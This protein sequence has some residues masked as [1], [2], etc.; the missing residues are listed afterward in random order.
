ML[1]AALIGYLD[2]GSGSMIVQ[3][4]VVALAGLAVVSKFYGRAI[5]SFLRRGRR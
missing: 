1:Q 5:L 2:T 3:L 4:V